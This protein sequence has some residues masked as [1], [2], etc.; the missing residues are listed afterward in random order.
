MHL[1]PKKRIEVFADTK[2]VVLRD[3][4]MNQLVHM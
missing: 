4:V 3:D 2:V 1:N